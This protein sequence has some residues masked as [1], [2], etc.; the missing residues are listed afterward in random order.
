[1]SLVKILLIFNRY[2]LF[3]ILIFDLIG[4]F[5]FTNINARQVT[6]FYPSNRCS[7]GREPYTARGNFYGR[8][9]GIQL[10]MLEFCKTSTI[11]LGSKSYKPL[12]SFD[13]NLNLKCV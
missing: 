3:V 8:L 13:S 1:M 10:K 7:S 6:Q 4:A 9:Q 5:V 12:K 2:F 11:V